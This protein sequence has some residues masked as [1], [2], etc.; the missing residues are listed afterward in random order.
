[1][2]N[3]PH[4]PSQGSF[5]ITVSPKNGSHT[6]VSCQSPV[7]AGHSSNCLATVTDEGPGTKSAPSGT[8]EFASNHGGAFANPPSHTCSLVA[9]P[10]GAPKATCSLVFTPSEVA[11]H[12]ITAS[13]SGD[14]NHFLSVGITTIEVTPQTQNEDA[15]ETKIN[16]DASVI[17]NH[18]AACAVT[19]T[20]TTNPGQTPTGLVTLDTNS[21]AS[22]FS[23]NP[24]QLIAGRCTITYNAA[25]PGAP[26][27]DQLT[28]T[29]NGATGF[30]AS[31]PATTTINVLAQ[32]A[33]ED[34]TAA[35]INCDA[36]VIVNH[37][38]ACAVTVTDTTNP[39]QTPT[40]LVTLD[41]NSGASSFS[42]N[43]CQLIAGRCTITYNAAGPGAPRAD[44]LT[45]T[46][47]G[48]T[49]FKASAPATTTINVLA[50][51]ANE[52]TTAAQINCDASVIVNHGAA[53]AVTVTDTT[54]PGQTPTGLV[55]LDTNSGASSFSENPCQLIAGRCTITYNAAG[56]GAPRADQ[57]TATYN[58]ATG[59]KAS[60]P[61]TTTINVLAQAANEDTTAAQIN[62]DASV[63][64]NHGA[65]CAVTV[66]DT[67]NPGQT[68]TG[69]VTLDTNSGASSFSENPCQLIAGRCTITYNAAGPGAP[70]ADQ[71][72]ATYN[73]ATGFKASA[74]ATT[75]INV[76][77]QAANEDT[78]A[79]QINCDAS[80][81]VNHGA[82]CAVT[83]T[84]TTN[85]GQTPT[86]LVTLDTN[87]GASSFSE[88]PCQL[89]AG[90]CTITYNAAG[91]GAPRADQLTATYNGATGFK[92]SAPATTTINVLAQ[93]ANED[94]TAAQINCD[95][96]VI[97]NHGA[98]CAVTVTDTTNPGQT[99]TGLVTLDTNSGASSF[100]ENPCQ[101]IAGRC[102]ITYNA[103]GPGA[104]RADQLT[105]TYNGATGFKASAPATTTINVLAQAANEDTTAAQINCDAS[106]I[107]NHGAACAV[108][109][110]DTTNPG[111]TPTG[112]VTL[113]T[114][115]GASSFS[116]NPCQL[117]AGRCTITY[118]AAGPG[119]P[120]ADQ[121]TATYNGATGFK[122]S[123]PATTTINVLAQ[124]ANEDT[125]AAQ[126]NCDASVIV[127]HGAACAVT[128]TDTTNPGQTPTGLVT[129]DTNSGASSFSENPCQLIAGRCTITYN[130]AG[131][132][133][134]RADQLTAT[135]N[136]AT[137]F[138]ASAPATTTIN[139]LAQAANEDTTAAQI[140][141][142]ASVIV[143]H[144]A[145][146]AVTVTDTT[147]PGQTPTGLVTLDTN[148]G[149]S[150]F[151]ENPCQLIAGR[152]TITY[153]AA[154]PGAPRADQLTA[155]YNGATGFKAS[156]PATTTINVLA[157]AAN[158]DTT[159]AQ[160]N[161]D[162]SVIVNHGAACAVTVT[163]TTNPGQTPT[164]LVTLDTNSGASSFSE[165]P[166]Q[167]I[168]GRCTITYNAAGPGAPRADQLTATYNGATGFKAS[169]PATT[170]INVL[171]QAA[172]E[173]TTAAQI[174]CDASVIV[175]H[176]AACAVTVTDTTNPGQTPTGL[177]TLDTNSGAS[178]FSEN[179]C[180]LIAGRCTITYN[181]AGPGAPRADQLTATYNGATGFKASAP[182]TTTINVLAQVTTT[183]N[184][185][186][187]ALSC[188][189]A[190]VILGGAS[191]CTATVEDSATTNKITPG[192]NVH[193]EST[194]GALPANGNCAVTEIADGKA[195][196]QLTYTPAAQGAG[197]VKAHYGGD[198]NHNGSEAETQVT[199]RAPNGGHDTA[200]A[201]SCNPANVILGGASI[202]TV[203][204]TDTA[205]TNASAPGGGV[206]FLG[207][208]PGAFDNG[209]CQ[210][211][212]VSQSQSR[213]QLLYTPTG[214]GIA[215]KVTAI[216][217]GE[218]GHEPSQN[219]VA[220]TVSPAN[221][222]DHT[223]TTI[224]CTPNTF[225]TEESSSC[226]ASVED[227][228]AAN[229]PTGAVVFASSG[230]GTFVP[231]GCNLAAEAG[232]ANKASCTIAYNPLGAGD[233][234]I[235]A[236]YGGDTGFEPSPRHHHP[237]HL[238]PGAPRNQ[239]GAGLR[240][241]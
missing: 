14:P 58:G 114:N 36:S 144:G 239:H 99:P 39:G 17:V 82:A 177:V 91:P 159:A 178:S 66:T 112:L 117:I 113:D 214:P 164:G 93:A 10:G 155:T 169:A 111:Q 5:T 149:A 121:L 156:A 77:A 64:V 183:K 217:P 40:G 133:A 74:P 70:R 152:C 122:A 85:P 104:P 197:T 201:L 33:N 141:C 185:T 25:G 71:L 208:G 87:S 175:N 132:G 46:Y 189:P 202:C 228:D 136:G 44:Q 209:G 56:P 83:V 139:V 123:A 131:P 199:A 30:K 98:A 157:Q 116:E 232:V 235:S 78:T 213:C 225:T 84:D 32:A 90:R 31:A 212:A 179:P 142:D 186:T 54:N 94:T 42:E 119:A 138:K 211:F 151:S 161:C 218:P 176:G 115:S 165:N 6:A 72:T 227:T 203:T 200:T 224:S 195:S 88:N 127:N 125:T 129:L 21:G 145:A 12:T 216:Y 67:T 194:A 19:V 215:H 16:C 137:G 184:D 102:T 47:N 230:A 8:V 148:S 110:T 143:N 50:Q 2:G 7:E 4:D 196:C 86:G 109:V 73:G 158:E 65:A 38:A 134:P 135:Y 168:A 193:L 150:S 163:D 233:A 61:A 26:R 97:V 207:E 11:S 153:N 180:Q 226:K 51:A 20:D 103:A 60:A 13:Y 59:F 29:Y 124:A 45:A 15:T 80:V 62:C 223:Q 41:T 69:L 128:V 222:G 100:S 231:G 55:T 79:A 181:A 174:N 147:N 24:C 27:A 241:E 171:A 107:V 166:C 120:R 126:I 118:N 190:N 219:S 23:E 206:I 96:S 18:G 9:D 43:P 105:A 154:G 188:E 95:A 221:G 170:T 146:C 130:A 53:C 92:A 75:T 140:N 3:G 81:I 101:L 34:T 160:I 198:A 89:I 76:L 57:L 236:G 172:N 182:A 191:A 63:I 22:S 35:Q 237:A 205:A 52:D 37:G 238:G 106:V 220:L 108:T 173:D 48:A 229:A 28:A 204:V 167:L 187:T 234:E 68:P 192:G 1:M 162:A 49:G 240:P 210:L